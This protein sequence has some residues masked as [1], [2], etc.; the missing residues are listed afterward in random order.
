MWNDGN[1]H[2]EGKLRLN[3]DSTYIGMFKDDQQNGEGVITFANTSSYQGRFANNMYSGNGKYI[4]ENGNTFIGE[5]ENSLYHGEGILYGKDGSEQNGLWFEGKMSGYGYANK[6]ALESI[7]SSLNKVIDDN[8]FSVEKLQKLSKLKIS[9]HINMNQKNK[10]EEELS[11]FMKRLTLSGRYTGP[12]INGLP[13]GPLGVCDYEDN[14]QYSGEWKVGKKNG[15]GSYMYAND[16]K[17]HGKW[18]GDKRC[19]WGKLEASMNDS[20]NN[21]Y[22]GI[23]YN[24][25]PH[26][27][28]V[29]HYKNGTSYIGEFKNGRKH[30]FGK[31]IKLDNYDSEHLLYE[32]EWR[33]D[34]TLVS[35]A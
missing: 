8:D 3:D 34:H 24:N 5:F 19:G 33:D 16:D 15:L 29:M 25:V 32:G 27:E 1:K 4:D 20:I 13:S 17:Y 9:N 2:G 28:G 30:G 35:D 12:L 6:L 10:G 23:W 31:I 14:S 7:N 22:E 11:P 18:V 21:S 26:G